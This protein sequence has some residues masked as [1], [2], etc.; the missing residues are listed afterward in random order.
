MHFISKHSHRVER[1]KTKYSDTSLFILSLKVSLC[2]RVLTG[3]A[4]KAWSAEHR[5]EYME[6]HTWK[7]MVHCVLYEKKSITSGHGFVL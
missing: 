7:Y 5:V 3:I 4:L 6:I 2:A 1:C